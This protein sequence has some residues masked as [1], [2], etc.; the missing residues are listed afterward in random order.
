MIKYVF[1]TNIWIHILYGK[2]PGIISKVDALLSEKDV[3]LILPF[4]ITAE[5]KSIAHQR[6]FGEKKLNE[7]KR[8]MEPCITINTTDEIVDAYAELDAFSQGK[9]KGKSLGMSARNM[10]KNDL[11]IAATALVTKSTLITTDSDFYHLSPKWIKLLKY[12]NK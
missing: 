10:G 2:P 5:L 4:C 3:F 1:D 9:L 8:I 7:L 11:W 6:E 12:E